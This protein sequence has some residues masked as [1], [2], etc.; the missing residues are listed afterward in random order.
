M[1][2]ELQVFNFSVYYQNKYCQTS[3]VDKRV[4]LIN[5]IQDR[6]KF[7]EAIRY[8]YEI[9]TPPKLSLN[10]YSLRS[11]ARMINDHGEMTAMLRTAPLVFIK[12]FYD[13]MTRYSVYQKEKEKEKFL[14]VIEF[15]FSKNSQSLVNYF[16]KTE[17]KP[18]I[19]NTI[20]LTPEVAPR[21]KQLKIKP[22]EEIES[23]KR[24][25]STP[26]R[27]INKT[28]NTLYREILDYEKAKPI[29]M[30][31]ASTNRH[32][33][34]Y[35]ATENSNK[36]NKNV[37]LEIKVSLGFDYKIHKNSSARIDY[38][39]KKDR[40]EIQL[41]QRIQ[42]E[43]DQFSVAEGFFSNH[44]NELMSSSMLDYSSIHL[45]QSA[46]T[47]KILDTDGNFK[48]TKSHRE[49]RWIKEND[50]KVAPQTQFEK[51]LKI[52][53]NYERK[54]KMEN[55]VEGRKSTL[56]QRKKS[57]FREVGLNNG[58][59][60]SLFSKELTSTFQSDFRKVKNFGK[61]KVAEIIEP[62]STKNKIPVPRLNLQKAELKMKKSSGL[63]CFSDRRKTDTLPLTTKRSSS[64]L[65]RLAKFEYKA[66]KRNTMPDEGRIRQ[67]FPEAGKTTSRFTRNEPDLFS[68]RLGR[69]N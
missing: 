38:M 1:F 62:P 43:E 13:I 66:S 44:N 24:I 69:L 28:L 5:R 7:S 3:V 41:V 35:E 59:P 27:S 6:Q 33:D 45:K 52:P 30:Q 15:L 21:M 57:S 53:R 54:L 25:S 58:N 12:D 9:Q 10:V 42:T 34:M 29:Q 36:S 26:H 51:Y 14:R 61:E 37:N 68:K 47:N 40:P 32:R 63:L 23:A 18:C 4:I 48:I 22:R 46:S 49:N 31:M 65:K 39:R 16:S 8:H 60:N 55:L 20:I 2:H 19:E 67:R 11:A 17:G 64:H 50:I 56:F